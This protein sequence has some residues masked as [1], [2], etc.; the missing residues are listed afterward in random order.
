[1]NEGTVRQFST[2]SEIYNDP[3]EAFVAGFLGSPP[4][5]LVKR[6]NIVVGFRPESF[7]PKAAYKGHADLEPLEFHVTRA[8]YLGSDRLLNGNL[9][10]RFKKH[11][12]V[13]KLTT[14][15]DMPISSG[16]RYEFAVPRDAIR[17]FNQDTG[18]RREPVPL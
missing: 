2:P 10:E 17:F 9:E 11:H 8:E 5:N 12:V 4:M 6:G 15:I 18:M 14:S 16:H 1:M 3:A 13:A 7:L